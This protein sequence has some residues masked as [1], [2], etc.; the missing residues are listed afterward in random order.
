MM[1]EN[2]GSRD[3]WLLCRAGTHLCALP[4]AH[5]LEVMR[6]LPV[7][8]L[9]DAP[10]FLR[11]IAVIRGAP[12]AVIDL[13]RLLGQAKTA[14]ARLVTV[15]VG[16]R[17]LALAV[18]EVLAVRRDGELG[19]HGA[20]PLLREVARESVSTIGTLDSEALLFLEELR[21]VAQAVPA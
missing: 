4:L 19:P 11:G 2:S 6:P 12:V 1:D 21:V 9:A 7:E 13:G 14:P 20:V 15:R 17:I 8:P 5:I 16:G 18:A 10:A 3:S